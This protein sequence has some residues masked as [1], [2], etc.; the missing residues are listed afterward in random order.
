MIFG[1][2]NG[3][4]MFQTLDTY[5]GKKGWLSENTDILCRFAAN[6]VSIAAIE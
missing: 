5:G 3:I 6:G 4:P 2:S 1:Y